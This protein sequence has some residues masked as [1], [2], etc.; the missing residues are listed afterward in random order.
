MIPDVKL[1]SPASCRTLIARRIYSGF[2][3]SRRSYN[4]VSVASNG[5][6]YYVLSSAALDKGAQMYGYDPARDLVS[7]LCD[8]TAAAG[9]TA[10]RAIPQGKSHVRFVETDGKLY[11]ATHV[12]YYDVTVGWERMGAPPA[13]Y[14]SYPGGH[15][16]SYDLSSGLVQDIS[17]PVAGQGII[18]MAM[19]PL[20][21]R[22]YGLTWPNGLLIIY[23]LGAGAVQIAPVFGDG[24]A[25]EGPAFSTICRALVVGDSGN[26]YFTLPTGEIVRYRPD[27]NS[28]GLVEGDN[29]R[30]DYFG[31]YEDS[32]PFHMSYHWRQAVWHPSER[33]IYGIH[34]TSGYLFRFD[35]SIE[36]V[37]LIER[38]TSET[39]RQIGMFDKFS[40][41]YLGM[42]FGPD[43]RTVYYLTGGIIM[44][45][46]GPVLQRRKCVGAQGQEDMHLVTF[47]VTSH[48][49]RD[50]GRILLDDG[51]RPT[52]VQS[53]AVAENG[54]IYALATMGAG[55]HE[56]TDLIE[57]APISPVTK[58]LSNLD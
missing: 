27:I 51:S 6:I 52:Y 11:F 33:V 28:I 50:H 26:V 13:G 32:S 35:P 10:Q 21:R 4:A 37:M 39:S 25:G 16:L 20:R 30:K 14:E 47:D 7:H 45:D 5:C 38:L 48:R 17:R 2:E 24:E 18:A 56:C 22:L 41:G 53:I 12:S 49:Y 23:D 29:L 55:D 3:N 58:P 40:H 8:L 54:Y 36:R 44:S 42:I 1:S 9:E 34:G 15:F 57:L 31:S 46:E 43:Q 19:D